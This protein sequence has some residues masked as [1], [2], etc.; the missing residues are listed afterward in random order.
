M[1]VFLCF[2][3]QIEERAHSKLRFESFEQSQEEANI[4][5]FPAFLSR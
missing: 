2:F 5:G 4:V 3:E 1:Q